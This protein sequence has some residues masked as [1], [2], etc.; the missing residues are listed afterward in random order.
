MVANNRQLNRLNSD[1][2]TVLSHIQQYFNYKVTLGFIGGVN[3]R[4][5]QNNPKSPK[6]VRKK[7][8]GWLGMVW[9]QD[10]CFQCSNMSIC[11]LLLQ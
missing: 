7:K 6:V 9:N 5:A 1:W 4:K 11:I 3:R 8:A 10:I 2:D